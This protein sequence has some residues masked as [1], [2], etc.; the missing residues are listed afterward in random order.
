LPL[1]PRS[2]IQIVMLQSSPIRHCTPSSGEFPQPFLLGMGVF[3]QGF[4]GR[5][6]DWWNLSVSANPW[7][8]VSIGLVTIYI[9][10]TLLLISWL[11]VY[12]FCV[13]KCS[14][15]FGLLMKIAMKHTKSVWS[16]LFLCVALARIL[17]ALN[18]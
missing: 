13:F 8:Q 11:C 3:V 16:Q 6:L 7:R 9:T 18:Y 10:C 17:C 14:I 4:T 1:M 5:A 2:K 12:I 15:S